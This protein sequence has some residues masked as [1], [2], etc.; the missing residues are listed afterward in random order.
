M[1]TDHQPVTTMSPTDGP[2]TLAQVLACLREPFVDRE[3]GVD[4]RRL[5]RLVA[6]MAEVVESWERE[7]EP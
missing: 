1:N 7:R 5:G 2:K 4:S 6:S 3:L